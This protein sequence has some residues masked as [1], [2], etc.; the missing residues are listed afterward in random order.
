MLKYNSAK[1]A[2]LPNT[3]HLDYE[4]SVLNNPAPIAIMKAVRE[5]NDTAAH[6]E[7]GKHTAGLANP[8]CNCIYA[9]RWD[10][11]GNLE[12]TCGLHVKEIKHTDSTN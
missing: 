9:I 11:K 1:L 10:A 3:T 8:I 2:T 5:G 4:R 6:I 12:F 7:A